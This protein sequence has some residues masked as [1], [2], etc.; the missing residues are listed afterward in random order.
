MD[1]L[2]AHTDRRLIQPLTSFGRKPEGF[3]VG[4]SVRARWMQTD[5][6]WDATIVAIAIG[7]ADMTI[8]YDGDDKTTVVPLASVKHHGADGP[9]ATGLSGLGGGSGSSTGRAKNLSEY[10]LS[11]VDFL[12]RKSTV[13][14]A[15]HG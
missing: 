14:H 7:A 4:D 2:P 1:D 12:P 15:R 11:G 6:F 13:C 10:T 9:F 8:R 5:N 3:T